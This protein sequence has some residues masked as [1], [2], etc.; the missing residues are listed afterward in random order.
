MPGVAQS[1]WFRN[2]ND[3]AQVV[4]P[5]VGHIK[6]V[7]VVNS[8]ATAAFLQ[9]FDQ[10]TNLITLGTTRPRHVIQVAANNAWSE[11]WFEMGDPY[12]TSCV[13]YATTSAEGNTGVANGVFLQAWIN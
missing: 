5:G 1:T 8:V 6:K 4:M 2:L 3:T 11:E 12:Y 13:V 10:A 9:F 7:L